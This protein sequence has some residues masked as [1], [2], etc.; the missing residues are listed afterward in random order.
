MLVVQLDALGRVDVLD[1][2]NERVHRRL[3]VREATQVAEVHEALRDLVAGAN[4]AAVLD[5]RHEAGA[6]GDA[7]LVQDA[8]VVLGVQD[9][10]EVLGLLRLDGELA[11]QRGQVGLATKDLLVH[12]AND[13]EH[14]AD[15]RQA[16]RDV[17]GACDAAGMNR[18]HRELRA[19]L[20][21]GLCGDDAHRVPTLTGRRV[22]RSQP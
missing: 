16:L 5:A 8:R 15:R 13:V 2:L 12:V 10:D 11:G 4:V 9:A 1:A 7:L 3:D 17:V 19:R 14:A 21:D 6:R 18:A 22:E 20:A